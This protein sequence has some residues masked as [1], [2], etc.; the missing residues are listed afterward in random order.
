VAIF[1]SLISPST[2]SVESD[3]AESH[4]RLQRQ[5]KDNH[6]RTSTCRADEAITLGS[7]RGGACGPLSSMRQHPHPETGV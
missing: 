5:H 4:D 6:A 1:S 3:V 2:S 7:V